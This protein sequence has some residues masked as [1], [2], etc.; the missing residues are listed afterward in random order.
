VDALRTLHEALVPRGK[1]V[2]TQPLSPQPPVCSAGGRL[3][4]LDMR[5]WVQTIQAVDEQ[6]ERALADDL[7]RLEDE[8]RFVVADGFDDGVECAE[9]VSE[10]EGTRVAPSLAAKI[11]DAMPPLTVEQEIRLRLLVRP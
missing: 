4:S 2:D 10:W 11:R 9:T 8:R 6:V 7:F 1:L 3:G 5:E